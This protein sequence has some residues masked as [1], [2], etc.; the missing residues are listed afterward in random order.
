MWLKIVDAYETLMD[1]V[2]RRKYD[3]TMPFDDEIPSTDDFTD[4]TFFDVFAAV[5]NR[6]ARFAKKKPQFGLGHID[7]PLNEVKS[8]YKYWNNFETWREFSQYDEYNLEEA[9]DRYERR[10]MEQENKKV[11]SK[12]DKKERQRLI[13]LS[14]MAYNN[15]PRIKKMVA[16][17]EAEKQRRK[18]AKK[19]FKVQ[20]ARQREQ[21]Q[22]EIDD[23]KAAELKAK[24]D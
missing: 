22:K 17:E 20:E 1:P 5:F 9:N 7:S 23:R 18:E 13:K 21:M 6:N 14:E 16:E 4:E 8:F 10:Y 12:Y 2:R 24:Q 11:R 19:E 3:S 15:D